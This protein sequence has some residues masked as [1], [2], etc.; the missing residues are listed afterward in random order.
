VLP[1]GRVR[2]LQLQIRVARD[3]AGRPTG[4]TGTVQDVTER[5]QAQA[6]LRDS[7]AEL[8]RAQRIAQVGSWVWHLDTDRATRSAEYSRILGIDPS[9]PE[10]TFGAHARFATPATWPRLEA[11]VRR[12]VAD[13]TPYEVELEIVRE[14][15]AKRWI[16][17][18][19]EP[20]READGTVKRLF[21]TI[22]DITERKRAEIDLRQARDQVRELS[23][24][25]EDELD[26]ERK[27]IAL[28]VH[29]EVGQMLTAMK[30][31]LDM[32]Q[33]HT[34][35]ARAVEVAAERLRGLVEDTIEV[36]RNVALNLRPAALD[37]GLV[38]ALE[39]LAED[40]T[41]RSEI[42]CRLQAA[43]GEV[44][45]GEKAATELFRI[46]QESLTNIARHARASRV[47]ITLQ[48]VDGALMMSIR[49]DGCGFDPLRARSLGRFGLLGMRERALRLDA[50]LLI[51]SRPGEG[52]TVSIQLPTSRA[53]GAAS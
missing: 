10:M 49:D 19:G 9:E 45:L 41:L 29:D 25:R 14:D 40:F 3:G 18:R 23:S 42:P 51:D 48:R 46:A 38:P 13:G 4:L 52:T 50:S 39:W 21:G 26:Q 22:Q 24:H 17:V 16:M 11:A 36:T 34:G 2:C 7:A 47:G 30:L 53:P 43:T 35:D 44:A 28:D 31:Q 12:A 6:A 20:A 37:L 32:L 1:D 27:R 33:S 15:G 5:E 8:A